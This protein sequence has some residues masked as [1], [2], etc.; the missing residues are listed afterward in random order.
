MKGFEKIRKMDMRIRGRQRRRQKRHH[1]KKEKTEAKRS[2]TEIERDTRGNGSHASKVGRR[3]L[4]SPDG[5]LALTLA[6]DPSRDLEGLDGG[7]A[8]GLLFA[9]VARGGVEV[10]VGRQHG[11]DGPELDNVVLLQVD[12]GHLARQKSR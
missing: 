3:D 4:E 6:P 7:L 10:E 1:K 12:K 11:E 9:L 5:G 2:E 8:P